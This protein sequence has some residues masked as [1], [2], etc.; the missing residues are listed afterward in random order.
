MKVTIQEAQQLA[1]DVLVRT[2]YST[3]GADRIAKHL[4]DSHL[5]GYTSAG[6]ARI[7]VIRDRL[8]GRAP[9]EAI[10]VTNETSVLAH[11]D[12]QDTFGYLVGQR[13]TEMAISKAKQ[14]G[15]SIVCANNTWTTGMLAYYSEMATKENLVTIITANSTP[16]VAAHG[17]YAGVHGTNPLCIGFP[18]SGTP[19]IVD[20]ATSKILHADIVLAQRLN[21]ELPPGAA[22]NAQ[23]EPTTNP[24]EVFQGAIAPWGGHRGS[25]IATAIQLLGVL[26]GSPAFPPTLG[27]F[28]FSII[29]I[30]PSQFRPLED[31]KKEVD[32]YAKRIR[33]SPPIAG[34]LPLRLPFERSAAL[35]AEALQA[36][37]V[38]VDDSL[39]KTLLEILGKKV[40]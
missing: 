13:A 36:G 1:H 28:G 40:D 20:I 2:G 37:E 30:D 15:I 33:E 3:E 18:S 39:Y 6:L 7:L 19:I 9:V 35:R 14:L 17:G 5:R 26:A 38:D 25:G 23:G 16:W 8:A 24:W 11:L 4:L 31:F 10:T 27:Q 12:G 34:G 29:A 32:L 21:T 22:F